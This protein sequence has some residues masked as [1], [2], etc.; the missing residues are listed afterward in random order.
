[1][2]IVSPN[3]RTNGR[4]LTHQESM[5]DQLAFRGKSRSEIVEPPFALASRGPNGAASGG[6]APGDAPPGGAATRPGPPRVQ[7]T[8]SAGPPRVHRTS[9]AS[10]GCVGWAARP[11]VRRTG[12]A[13][14]WCRASRW[15]WG[16]GW[17]GG[18]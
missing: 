9:S 7:R 17:S 18:V 8:G 1:M 4:N 16:E 13:T 2:S 12:G 10:R 6:A 11:A 3:P 14:P 15:C 5:K